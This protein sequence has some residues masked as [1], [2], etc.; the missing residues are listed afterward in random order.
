MKIVGEL[1][2]SGIREFLQPG[3]PK[4]NMEEDNLTVQEVYVMN[5][6]AME[7]LPK[8]GDRYRGEM[9]LRNDV[10]DL[11]LTRVQAHPKGGGAE[12][13]EVDLEYGP[14]PLCDDESGSGRNKVRK[15]YEMGSE[16]MDV[17]LEQHPRYRA[18]WN[19][20]LLAQEGVAAVPAWWETATSTAVADRRYR[21]GAPD[22]EPEEGWHVLKNETKP[23][24]ESFRNGAVTVTVTKSCLRREGFEA[25]A[26]SQDYTRGKPGVTF[27]VGGEWLRGGSSIRR[28]GRR[29]VMA[30]TYI[31]AKQIDEDLYDS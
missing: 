23:G 27:G 30:V 9:P 19:H 7:K 28:E 15:W 21:W 31:N 29:W 16:E 22:E 25:E 12:V 4:I 18:C 24:V 26:K 14:K 8:I 2:R 20:R 6:R 13:W 3:Y 5:P 10:G 1:G 17:P 11:V